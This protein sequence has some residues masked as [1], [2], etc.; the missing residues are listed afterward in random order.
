MQEFLPNYRYTIVLSAKPYKIIKKYGIPES[1][2]IYNDT[3]Y[4]VRWKLKMKNDTHNVVKTSS[5]TK[6]TVYLYCQFNCTSLGS[7]I[8]LLRSRERYL[9]ELKTNGSKQDIKNILN[10]LKEKNI[11]N[12]ISFDDQ[13]IVTKTNLTRA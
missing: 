2:G 1:L 3:F 8:I 5:N 6:S 4:I 11:I 9:I 12:S 7:L 13:S 10:K